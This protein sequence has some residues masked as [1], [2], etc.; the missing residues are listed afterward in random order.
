MRLPPFRLERYFAR[1]EFSVKHL[2]CAS[3]AESLT[4]GE[5]LALEP[6]AAEGLSKLRLGY[7]ESPGGPGLRE[8]IARQYASLAP[9]QV[10][11]H[12]GSEE[13]IFTFLHSALAPGDHVIAHGPAYQSLHEVPRAAGAEVSEWRGQASEGWALDPDDLPKLLRPAT[14]GVILNS[15]HNPTGWLIPRERLDATID[16]ARRHGLWIFS[17]EVYRGLEHD[18]VGA[19]PSVADLYER[20]VA[21]GGLAKAYGLPGLRIGWLATKE[22]RWLDAA[23]AF[24]DYLTI[25]NSAP[26]ELLATVALAH[27]E[28]LVARVRTICRDNLARLEAL[29]ERHADRF[30]WTRPPSTTMAFPRVREDDATAFCERLLEATGVLLL[31][32]ALMGAGEHVRIG[33]GRL[34]FP[35]GLDRLDEY[36][37]RP[38]LGGR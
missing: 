13:P 16:F 14:R 12:A 34:D 15:P 22:T 25:C 5:L 37:R 1:H 29:M 26:S 3:D 32:G 11:V 17:D 35:A 6:G 18:G 20:G 36:L 33:Y 38:R 2:L 23:G 30:E 31:P 8:A 4:V 7:T 21:L 28:E 10:L 19:N 24:K 9:S 27:A